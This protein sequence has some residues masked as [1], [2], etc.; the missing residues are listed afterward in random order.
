MNTTTLSRR[1]IRAIFK[2][3]RGAQA[4]AARATKVSPQSMSLWLRGKFGSKRL[5]QEVEKFAANLLLR[6]RTDR[7]SAA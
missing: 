4:E 3:N 5:E 1:E 7:Q 2:R 6:E